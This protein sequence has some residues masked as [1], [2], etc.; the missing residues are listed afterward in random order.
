L[1]FFRGERP[2]PKSHSA[3]RAEKEALEIAG[4][5]PQWRSA[6][7]RIDDPDIRLALFQDTVLIDGAVLSVRYANDVDPFTGLHGF[8][9]ITSNPLVALQIENIETDSV[10]SW[11][12]I[13]S[14]VVVDPECPF[15]LAGFS[16]AHPMNVSGAFR[17]RK[18]KYIRPHP[19]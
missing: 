10:W 4:G 13:G 16:F 6:V 15:L 3:D 11:W 9:E 5:H 12:N 2:V 18:S 19:R 1:D 14:R 7:L 8:L 17:V